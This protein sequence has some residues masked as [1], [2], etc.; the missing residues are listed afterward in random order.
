L[1]FSTHFALGGFAGKGEKCVNVLVFG[2]SGGT[3][4]ELVKQALAQRHTV[5]A[6]VRDPGT[7]AIT[8][9]RLTVTT[10]D[11]VDSARVEQAVRGQD[12]V[13]SAL[14]SSRSL[15]RHPALAEG[16]QNIVKAMEH[17]GVRR[18][19]YLSILGVDDSR[20]Q[21]GWLDRFIVVPLIL[22]NVVA[23]HAIQEGLIRRSSLDWVI[24]RPPRLTNRAH[25]GRYRDGEDIKSGSMSASI[26]RADVAD[27][28]LRQMIDEMYVH[29]SPAI[30]Y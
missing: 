23:D 15:T 7:F 11:V 18:L 6:F 19:V 12:A 16:V 26:S 21:L 13:M 3:G 17:E 10:G 24:V 4:R 1:L 27:F 29:R 14:G 30:M 28:M 20:G 25:T 8:Q 5:T 9:D 22:R 2:A